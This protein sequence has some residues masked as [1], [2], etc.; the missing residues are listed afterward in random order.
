[1]LRSKVYIERA[2]KSFLVHDH[3]KGGG[4]VLQHSKPLSS[5]YFNEILEVFK[6]N[7]KK[8]HN[9]F[10]NQAH[11]GCFRFLKSSSYL[12]SRFLNPAHFACPHFQALWR[13]DPGNG[14]TQNELDLGSGDNQNEL[15]LGSIWKRLEHFLSFFF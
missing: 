7:F 4:C 1:M 10:L 2:T 12:V 3:F 6:N 9:V 11:V 14:D 8:S 15:D 13:Q 5:T